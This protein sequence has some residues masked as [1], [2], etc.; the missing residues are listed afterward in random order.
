[1]SILIRIVAAFTLVIGIGLLQSALTM[2]SI[3]HLSDQITVVA[4]R[5][6]TLV[7]AARSA[8]DGFRD[9]RESLSEVLAG[10]RYRDSRAAIANLKREIGLVESDLQRLGAAGGN[11]PTAEMS[12]QAAAQIVTWKAA[13]L[14]LLGE[15]PA[16]AIP[17]PHVMAQR[18]ADVG[19]VLRK[20]VAVALD[21][22]AAARVEIA[23]SAADTRQWTF[24]LAIAA[25]LG[26]LGLAI[27]A[28]MSIT[29]PL[30]RSIAAMDK[31]ATGD[32]DV[33]LVD[34]A[35]KDEV[36]A[37]NRAVLVFREN[38]IERRRLE[39]AEQ[40]NSARELKRQ[41]HLSEQLLK[42]R[43]DITETVA[44]LTAQVSQL[45]ATAKSLTDVTD[46]A[47]KEARGAVEAVTGAA[48]NSRTVAVST[49][50]LRASMSE[51]AEQASKTRNVISN[52]VA[53]AERSNSEIAGLSAAAAKIGSVIDLI[54]SIAQQT[55]LLALNATIEAARAGEAGRGFAVVASEVKALAEQTAKATEEVSR[56]IATVQDTT[57]SA[58]ASIRGSFRS[59][60]EISGMAGSIAAAVEQQ[61]AATRQIAENVAQAADRSLS[62]ADNVNNM[63]MV[64]S[65]TRTEA[66]SV[67]DVSARIDAVSQTISAAL[68]SFQQAISSDLQER[69]Q[70]WRQAISWTVPVHVGGRRIDALATE[71]SFG[72]M[73]FARLDGVE[74]GMPLVV[75]LDGERQQA[76]VAWTSPVAMGVRFASP[77]QVLPRRIAMA[78]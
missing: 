40:K 38:L 54:R 65:H 58:V 73:R 71:L 19:A 59:L 4:E 21:E 50:E 30:K 67:A 46:A 47:S 35:R 28:A 11:G 43:K 78:G 53:M 39:E 55:N 22:A 62:A 41:E 68:A 57:D 36:G 75:E 32:V 60:D 14:V 48:D 18:E 76:S 31:L 3:G 42:F 5:P 77:L 34:A 44:Q 23:Q 69:R 33:E 70:V 37:M 74:H 24:Y 63:A 52:A 7:D 2:R 15:T 51:I 29:R 20:L 9:A 61:G 64:A 27:G 8:W 1:M 72:G 13:A 56:Q 10:D 45:G 16:T 6:V 26:G 49:D 12:R 66:G 17:A 25:A